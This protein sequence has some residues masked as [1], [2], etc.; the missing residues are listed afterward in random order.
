MQFKY[1]IILLC[2]LILVSCDSSYKENNTKNQ[3]IGIVIHGG[4]GTILR[5]NM[6]PEKESNYR[7]VLAEAIHVGYIILKNGGSS[8]EAVEKTINIM[9]DSPLF[10]AGK[11]AVLP[12]SEKVVGNG[13]VSIPLKA[14]G[15]VFSSP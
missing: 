3:P 13:P 12:V 5:K 2:F 9:E 7:K 15:V 1:S 4:A 11:G 8:Q 6:T 10:N 14:W